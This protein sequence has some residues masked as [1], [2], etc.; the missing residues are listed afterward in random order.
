MTARQWILKEPA[1]IVFMFDSLDH[2]HYTMVISVYVSI[3]F[4]SRFGAMPAQSRRNRPSPGTGVHPTKAEAEKEATRSGTWLVTG[5]RKEGRERLR[6]NGNERE[7]VPI[8][9][10]RREP[11]KTGSNRASDY[12]SSVTGKAWKPSVS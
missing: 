9:G 1:A 7:T 12:T 5:E 4:D 10:R 6:Q 2:G 8:L 3:A 11:N